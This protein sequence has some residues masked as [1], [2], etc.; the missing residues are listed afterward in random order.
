MR[1]LV[2]DGRTGAAGDMICAA[3][4]A[5]G[6]DPDILAPVPDR[7][8]IRYEVGETTRNGL[9]ATTVDVLLDGD[10]RERDHSHEH[11]HSHEHDHDGHSHEHDHDGHSHEHDHDGHSH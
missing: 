10:D 1:T 6:A 11:G 4:I 3:L 2:F 8:P 5:A 9:R 7:P